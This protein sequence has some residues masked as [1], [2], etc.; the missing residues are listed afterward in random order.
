MQVDAL[1]AKA[2]NASFSATLLLLFVN[3]HGSIVNQHN[4]AGLVVTIA[5]H[6][7]PNPGQHRACGGGQLNHQTCDSCQIHHFSGSFLLYLH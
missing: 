4:R 3:G 5:A 7:N 6:P 2:I 1:I